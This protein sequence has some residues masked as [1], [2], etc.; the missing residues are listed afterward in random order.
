MKMLYED[1]ITEINECYDDYKNEGKYGRSN[2]KN[3]V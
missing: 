2:C 1:Y 3:F